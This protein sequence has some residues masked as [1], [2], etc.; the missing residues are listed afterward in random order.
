MDV[1]FIEDFNKYVGEDFFMFSE[2]EDFLRLLE[3]MEFNDGIFVW[4]DGVLEDMIW[5]FE[6][7]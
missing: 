2:N 3:L 7:F 4:R 1:C 5:C 6:Y